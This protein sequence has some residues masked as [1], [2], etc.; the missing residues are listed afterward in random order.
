MGGR[1]EFHAFDPQQ[2]ILQQPA[3][4]GDDIAD[5]PQGEDLK[6]QDIEDGGEDEGLDVPLAFPLK[7]KNKVAHRGD[8]PA[9]EAE[10]AQ[11]VK[12]L[13]RLVHGVNADHGV[14]L[15]HQ[16]LGDAAKEPGGA[17]LGVGADGGARAA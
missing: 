17:G 8:E 11:K 6:A 3:V 10:P 1:I 5:K 9:D 2:N 13:E 15:A 12:H 4:E 16:E 7:I 14:E